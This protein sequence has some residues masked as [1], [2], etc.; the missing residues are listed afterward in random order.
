MR[1]REATLYSLLLVLYSLPALPQNARE[2]G[3]PESYAA[4]VDVTGF[5]SF[6]QAVASANALYVPPGRHLVENPV[7]IDR[8]TPLFVH[9]AD[10][11]GATLVG[12]NPGKPLFVIR[13]AP[14]VSIASLRLFA[15]GDPKAVDQAALRTENKA[16][17]RLEIMDGV[18]EDSRLELRGPGEVRIQAVSFA[19]HGRVTASVLIDHAEA[20]VTLVGGNISHHR[21]K[22]RIETGQ[23]AH[24]WQKRG[25][26][27]IFGTGM[28]ATLGPSD[29]RIESASDAGPHV[30]VGVRS[31][32]ANGANRG[33][34]PCRLLTVPETPGAVDVVLEANSQTCGPLGR[35]DG[36]IVDYNARGTLWLLGNNGLP[37]AGSLVVGK[38][39]ASR[40][41]AVGNLI[42][43][44][45][46][47]VPAGTPGLEAGA[48]LAQPSRLMRKPSTRFLPPKPA[49]PEGIAAPPRIEVPPPLTRPR[50]TAALPGMLDVR[51]F[52]AKG[53]GVRDDTRSLQS[54]LDAAC[55]EGPK[56]VF[57]PA[58][59]YR[60]TAVLRF[61]HERARCRKHGVGGW[62]AGAGSDRTIIQRDPLL[63]GGVFETQGMAYATVQGLTF[64]T[65]AYDPKRKSTA[66]EPAFALENKR[67]VG[68][69]TQDV[70]FH[71]VVFDG[72]S[73]ALAIGVESPEQCSENLLVDAHF[74]HAHVGLAV[75]AYNALANIV[76]RGRFHDN[77][78]TLGHPE[79]G[80]SGGTW[81]V[82]GA[83]V[84]GTRDRE[85]N[86]RN[87]AT[88]A[89]YL[90]GLDSDTPSL[91]AVG[92]T[93]AAFPIVIEGAT[94][95]PRPTRP[96]KRF[97]L[98]GGGGGL[99]FLRGTVS[100]LSPSLLGGGMASSYLVGLDSVLP[101]LSGVVVGDNAVATQN[102]PAA[103]SGPRE[104]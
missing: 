74:E 27:R 22:A 10:R 19:P 79:D 11:M 23:A 62:I 53:D 63:P 39:A 26:L 29:V 56:L 60:T 25:R 81:M 24:V 97:I 31:E 49:L 76:M 48:N 13:R 73:H 36:A 94:L 43:G 69:A 32:G 5:D 33:T 9:G 51:S 72:G 4:F 66:W 1:L 93:G 41:V 91:V 28:Q 64:R 89:W 100:K 88:A 83:H 87:A 103:P 15:N 30:L 78:I 14:L 86:L 102:V 35:S 96:D 2:P 84:R 38:T 92:G 20:N 37:G 58:G 17:V 44:T 85:M 42:Q 68:P 47:L 34:Y 57:L 101:D 65:R 12:K 80:L 18:V 45:H 98:F 99:I 71:D 61:N 7:V 104:D 52:G 50:L 6:A 75:G 70:S 16:P 46:A 40:I 95:R 90:N 82:L 55:G 8:A 59:T 67:G 3:R 77:D 54:A 21:V